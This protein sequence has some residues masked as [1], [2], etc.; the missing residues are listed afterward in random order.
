M[1]TY[2]KIENPGVCP[3]DFFTLLGASSK[4]D[5]TELTSP[6]QIGKFGSGNKHGVATCLRHFVKPIV[7]CGTL[8]ME[9]DTRAQQIKKGEQVNN[10]NRVVVK[11]SGKTESGDTKNSTDD[12]GIVLNYGSEDWEDISMALREFVSNAIDESIEQEESRAIALCKSS[13]LTPEESVIAMKMHRSAAKPWDLVTIE[14]VQENQVRAKAGTTRVFIEANSDV[15]EFFNNL[16]KWFL[17]FSEPESLTKTV[18]DKTRNRALGSEE[19]VIYR[20]GVRVRGTYSKSVFDYNLED[21]KLDESRNVDH[22][23]VMSV[24]A[25]SFVKSAKVEQIVAYLQCEKDSFEGHFS[26]Y[27]MECPDAIRAERSAVWQNA[28][29]CL[30]GPNAVLLPPDAG[31]G[32]VSALEQKGYVGLN[33]PHGLY[34]SADSLNL[35]VA[36]DVLNQNELDG[37]EIV[38]LPKSGRAAFLQCWTLLETFNL[39]KNKSFPPTFGFRSPMNA[40]SVKHG[41]C[42]EGKVYINVVDCTEGSVPSVQELKIALEELVHYVTDARD[43]SRDLQDFAF[44]LCA[45]QMESRHE[46]EAS[47]R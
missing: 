33:V 40:G 9:F 13:N 38:D 18:L 14:I 3:P 35:K 7:F 43:C 24:A 5:K 46:C 4:R 27:E 26:Y 20:R 15:Q 39:T 12:L 11:Y 21:L 47:V 45:L 23:T 31:A 8:K 19:G 44:L 30:G 17:H 42:R 16:G 34:H 25:K 10:F 41:L 32:I 1:T 22:S 36:S 6:F 2:L 37:L 29:R 28:V